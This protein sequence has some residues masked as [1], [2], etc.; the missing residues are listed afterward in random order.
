MTTWTLAIDTSHHVA[1]GLAADGVPRDS[2]VVPDTR[3]HGEALMPAI[4]KVC[5]RQGIALSD[6]DEIVVGMGPGPFTGLRVGIVTARTIAHLGAK[7]LHAV[8]SLDALA[9]QWSDAPAEFVI[10][11]DA[12]RKELYWAHYVDGVRVGEPQVSAPEALPAVPVAGVV[13]E[14][15][16]SVVRFVEG[17]QEI[18]PA[19]MAARWNELPVAG[20]EPYYLRQADATVGGAPKST[21]PTTRTRLRAPR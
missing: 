10:A 14:A 13:P 1:V 15:Y 4:V 19:T 16:R 17:P 8:C 12:R 21:I 3:A 6:V 9:L 5:A 2:I 7:P 18:D 20:D 11:S